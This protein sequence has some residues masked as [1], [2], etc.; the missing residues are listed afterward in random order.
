VSDKPKPGGYIWREDVQTAIRAN[1]QVREC[2]RRLLEERPSQALAATL[3]AQAACYLNVNQDA[4]H[5]L[6]RIGT[7]GNTPEKRDLP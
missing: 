5:E 1:C 7:T 3:I 2:L 4:L 6:E